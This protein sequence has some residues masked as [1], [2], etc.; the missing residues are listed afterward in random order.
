MRI[1]YANKEVN[2]PS[3]F[4][5]C[6]YALKSFFCLLLFTLLGGYRI[7]RQKLKISILYHSLGIPG[8][9]L[10]WILSVHGEDI[11]CSLC[12]NLRGGLSC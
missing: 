2:T 10:D 5:Y 1:Y 11:F 4:I 7:Q 6:Q 9:W 3:G 8:N 12:A